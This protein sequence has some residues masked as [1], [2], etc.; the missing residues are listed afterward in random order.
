MDNGLK[1][2]LLF[3]DFRKAFDSVNHTILLEKNKGNWYIS[4]FLAY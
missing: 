2:G 3:I 4:A 1:V